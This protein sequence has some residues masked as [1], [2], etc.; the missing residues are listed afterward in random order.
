MVKNS[1]IQSL[2]E[3]VLLLDGAMGTMIQG[4]DLTDAAFGGSAFKMLSDLLT[5]SRPKELKQIHLEYL[6]AGANILETNTFGASPLRLAEFDFSQIQLADFPS[7]PGGIDLPKLSYEKIA[8]Y[9]SKSASELAKEA[10]EV[11]RQSEHYDGRPLF[12]AGSIG[13]SNWVLSSTTANLR[14]GTF[15]QIRENFYHQVLGLIDG[16]TDILLFETQ[17]D[18]LELKAGIFGAHHAMNERGIK[19]PIIAQVTV[20]AY[21]KMQIFNTDIQA[22]MVTIS[23]LGIDVFGINCSIGP[24]LMLPTIKKLSQYCPLPISVIPNAGLPVSEDGKTVFK[25]TAEDFGKFHRKFVEEFGVNL[26]GG[27]CGTTPAHI[28]AVAQEI[29]GKKPI[30]RQIESGLFLSGPQNAIKIDSKDALIMIGERL[31]VRG[32]AKV[33]EAVEREGPIDEAALEEV[34]HEQTHDL[35]LDIIDVCM[36]S[37]L[38]STEQV[39]PQV[40]RAMTHDFKGAMCIDSFSVEALQEGIEAYCGLPIINSISLEEYAPGLDKIDAVLSFAEPHHP[41]YIA[42]AT[43]R[44]GPAVTAEKKVELAQKIVEKTSQKYGVHPS[45]LFIDVNA[46][47]IGAE[48]EEGMNFSVESLQAIPKIKALHPDL[49]TSI[50]IGNLTNGLA[51]KPHMRRV[52]TSIFLDE[53]RK[54]GLDAAIVNPNHYVPVSSLDPRDYE[55]GLKIILERDM[56]AF[57]LLEE[58]ADQKKGNVVAKRTSYDHLSI[59]EAICSKIIDGYKDRHKGTIE[60]EGHVFEYQDKIVL[61]V[62]EAIKIHEP[63]E[64][65]NSHLMAAMKELGDGFGRGDVSLPHLLKSADVMKQAMN[66]LESYMKVKAG[67]DVHSQISYKGT[68]VLGTVYQDVHSIGKDLTKTLLENYGYRVIDLGVQVPLQKFIDT[69]K[70][71]QADVIGMSAL[72]VQTSNHMISVSK[73]LLEQG[74]PHIDLLIGGAPVNLRHASY[75]AMAGQDD[76]SKIRENVFYC[77]SGM[78]GVNTMNQLKSSNKT[79]L[80]QQNREQLVVQYR[81]AKKMEDEAEMLLK[82]LPRRL[83][84]F[85]QHFVP[86]TFPF[87]S[88]KKIEVPLR[89]FKSLIDR[90]TLYSLNWKYGGKNSWEKKGISWDYL[91]EKLEEWIEKASQFGWLQPRGVI[92]IYPCVSQGDMVFVYDP[93][94]THQMIEQLSFSLVIGRN[95]QDIFSAA[96]YYRPQS[97]QRLDAIGFQLATAGYDIEPVLQSFKK[98]GDLESALFLQGLSDRIAE[99]MAEYLHQQMKQ[100]IGLTNGR[101]GTRYSPGYPAIKDLQNNQKISHLLRGEEEVGVKL[102]SAWEFHPTG[103]TAAVVCFHPEASYT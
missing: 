52:L 98:E 24:D 100:M 21:S 31:N 77:P 47:P 75:V 66:F 84:S 79:T 78:D 6:Y 76:L 12:V 45:R 56:D 71:Y 23:G 65:I 91:D 19:L 28:S 68:V 1:F 33:K 53:G 37:N 88:R 25:F 3:Q 54:V 5:F 9:L 82:T 90:K 64:F 29:R 7:L 36:D 60:V 51:K 38:V 103:S 39:L 46:F 10:I 8:Y 97:S 48:S 81:R 58:I 95:K 32:S 85:E 62:V 50:G 34:V 16:G 96:Q 13:P 15:A 99:D 72:L 86:E 74:L 80:L 101:G 26:V 11:Y 70:E 93:E 92:G 35:G 14:R 63:L 30:P 27:C 43:D 2:Q 57:A 94:Q 44:E 73:M 20:D 67:I 18:A 49:K 89:E 69:A 87:F 17:Q 59:E 55:L 102:T 22:A 40:I 42:L 83:I 61:Q 4:L 41:F